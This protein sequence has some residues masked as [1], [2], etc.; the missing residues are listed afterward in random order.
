L[1]RLP[2][3]SLHP[4]AIQH[5]LHPFGS[6]LVGIFLNTSPLG[7]ACS[8]RG[9]NYCERQRH[10]RAQNGLS[11]N[12]R[13]GRGRF[14]TI[15]ESC[16]RK[17]RFSGRRSW[18]ERKN[19]AH[20]SMTTHN[21]RNI[22]PRLR[23]DTTPGYCAEFKRD[24]SFCE[25]QHH[26]DSGFSWEFCGATVARLPARINR[27]ERLPNARRSRGECSEPI[28]GIRMISALHAHL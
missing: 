18:R 24:P 5:P 19:R 6:A 9:W 17:A 7:T 13:R 12:A 14:R 28:R 16:C 3:P 10:R 27:R 2:S 15:T 26:L 21:I 1:C 8:A 11:S 22:S 23:G 4:G 20:N 25:P